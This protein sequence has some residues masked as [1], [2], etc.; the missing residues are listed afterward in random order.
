MSFEAELPLHPGSNVVSVWARETPD[1][2]SHKVFV[3]RKDGPNGELLSSPKTEDD[4]G[5]AMGGGG[6]D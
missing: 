5:E 2:T 3:I 6:D 1:T 4:L